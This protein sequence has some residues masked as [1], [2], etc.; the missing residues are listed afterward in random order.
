MINVFCDC[1]EAKGKGN[2]ARLSL[3]AMK[4]NVI[5]ECLECGDMKRF[6]DNRGKTH[7]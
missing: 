3:T 1:K 6:T 5:I 2:D 4:G 7:Q